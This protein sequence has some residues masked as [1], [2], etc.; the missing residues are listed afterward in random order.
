MCYLIVCRQE[1]NLERR[2]LLYKVRT[3]ATYLLH[4]PYKRMLFN[5]PKEVIA[6]RK[7]ADMMS[8]I[9]KFIYSPLRKSINAKMKYDSNNAVQ[10]ITYQGEQ[11]DYKRIKEIA[12]AYEFDFIV[13]DSNKMI[14]NPYIKE[15]NGQK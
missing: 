4:N 3:K 5:V 2:R 8:K 13:L 9:A 12:A 10:Y 14:A 1:A 7:Q 6:Y 11:F 15:T